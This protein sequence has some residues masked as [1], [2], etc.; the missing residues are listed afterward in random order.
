MGNLCLPANFINGIP[1]LFLGCAAC[2]QT[3]KGVVCNATGVYCLHFESV[4]F[5]FSTGT[6]A[7]ASNSL[8]RKT[9][10]TQA[11]LPSFVLTC[12]L[13]GSAPHLLVLS[14]GNHFLRRHSTWTYQLELQTQIASRKGALASLLLGLMD[15][16][17]QKCL[18]VPVRVLEGHLPVFRD[19]SLP[20]QQQHTLD[21]PSLP[22]FL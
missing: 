5:Y 4:E 22:A 3:L 12:T 21:S 11:D 17:T 7:V 18:L 10:W 15:S 1:H 19:G 13:L 6:P 20:I 8:V 14:T 9:T 2:L 16:L